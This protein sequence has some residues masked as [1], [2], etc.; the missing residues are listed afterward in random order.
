MNNYPRVSVDTNMDDG[1]CFGCGVNN[2]IGLKLD[3]KPE[4]GAVCAEFTPH[5]HLQGWSGIMHGGIISCLLDEAMSYAAKLVARVHCITARMVVTMRQPISITETLR[6]TGAV[7]RVTRKIIES[8]AEISL[9]DGTVVAES[10][11]K[12][13]VVKDDGRYA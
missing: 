11:A 7:T 9:A 1:L 8:R 5:E 2:P 10:T 3:F 12:Q 6:V 13:F 4:N